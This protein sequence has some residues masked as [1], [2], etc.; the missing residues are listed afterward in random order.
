MTTKDQF[1]SR[2]QNSLTKKTFLNGIKTTIRHRIDRGH[3]HM[4]TTKMGY[5]RAHAAGRGHICPKPGPST[6]PGDWGRDGAPDKVRSNEDAQGGSK[7]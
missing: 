5:G 7:D 4:C 2:G 3:G 6:F 1:L